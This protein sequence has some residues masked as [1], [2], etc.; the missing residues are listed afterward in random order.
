MSLIDSNNYFSLLPKPF[1][2]R[3]SF[4][5]P[6][7]R[8]KSNEDR[9]ARMTAWRKIFRRKN[10]NSNI[11]DPLFQRGKLKNVDLKTFFY[12][13]MS[14]L[15]KEGEKEVLESRLKISGMTKEDNGE[16]T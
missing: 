1:K 5:I 9:S 11:H 15:T 14:L 16:K 7:S 8:L 3:S 4:W 12:L 6:A 13:P 10:K 2:I